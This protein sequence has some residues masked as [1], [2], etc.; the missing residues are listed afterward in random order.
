MEKSVT[1]PVH[2]ALAVRSVNSW[3]LILCCIIYFCFCWA[4]YTMAVEPLYELSSPPA[5]QADSDTYFAMAG[6]GNDRGVASDSL[7]NFG[8][9]SMGPVAI[10]LLCRT[11]FGVACFDCLLFLVVVYWAGLIPGVRREYFAILMAIEPQTVPTLMTLNKEICAIAGLVAFAAYLYSGRQRGK[12]HGSRW[13]LLPVVVFSIF[14]RWEQ[15]LV[16]MWY[17]AVESRWS[18]FRGKPRRAVIALLL[19]LSAAWAFAIHIVHLNLSGFI[20]QAQGGTIAR[21]YS[22][23]EKGGYFLVALPKILMNIAGRWVTPGYFLYDYWQVDFAGSWQNAYIGIL[24]SLCMLVVLAYAIFRG[25]FRV[26]R[27]LIHLTVIYFVCTA[28]NPFIQHRYIYPG[29]AFVVLEL[30]RRKDSLE[31]TPVLP[32]LPSLPPSYRVWEQRAAGAY[33]RAGSSQE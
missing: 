9:S 4:I 31:P 16:P 32:K 23:Q 2:G 26:S 19:I 27:P 6:L 3:I 1:N 33:L 28:V 5:I 25:R 29:Y 8:G 22:I 10:A 30:S 11:R 15:L 12:R 18:P 17:L 21:L 7:V 13:L 14:A 20:D 24:S